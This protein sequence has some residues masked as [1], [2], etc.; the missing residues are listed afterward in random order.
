MISNANQENSVC[1]WF[2]E[3]ITKKTTTEKIEYAPVHLSIWFMI[4]I[5]TSC[6]NLTRLVV[7]LNSECNDCNENGHNANVMRENSWRI[8]DHS[9]DD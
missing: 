4:T 7:M 1:F 3:L 6:S 8:Y 5:N 2:F 9:I